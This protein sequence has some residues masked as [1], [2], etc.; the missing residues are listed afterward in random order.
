MSYTRPGRLRRTLDRLGVPSPLMTVSGDTFAVA[1]DQITS[2]SISH[3]GTDP[4]PGVQPST[5]ETVI[6]RPSWIKTGEGLEVSITAAAG[7]AIAARTGIPASRFRRRFTGRVGV[8]TNTDSARSISTRLKAASWSAQLSRVAVSAP[9]T[10]GMT[11]GRAVTLLCDSPALPQV[12]TATFG[13]WDVLAEAIP[14]AAYSDIGKLTSE[15]GVLARDT[16]AGVLEVW[17]LEARMSWAAQQLATQ[18]PLTRSQA[19]SPSTWEQPNEDLPAKVRADWIGADGQPVARSAGGTDD[20]VVE[21]H[22]WTHV[23]AQTNS[24]DLHFDALLGRQ[25]NRV[26]QVPSVSVDILSLL[27]SDNE[28][29]QRQ[30][31]LLLSLNAGDTIGFS[32]DWHEWLRGIQVVTGIDEQIDKETWRLNLAVSPHYLVWGTQGPAVP[33]IIWDSATYSW[34][35]ES[36]NWNLEVP[37]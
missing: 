10:A 20:S 7:T 17:S 19:L 22:D 14:D 26:F 34:N 30:A 3:G 21:R 9:L 32:G 11:I 18:Y 6:Q 13:P 29:D 23:K 27:A 25:W 2:L 8:Q 15:I 5:C 24:L 35:S 12:E 28:Y 37:A 33:P 36:R 31:G 1:D 4:S 16:R